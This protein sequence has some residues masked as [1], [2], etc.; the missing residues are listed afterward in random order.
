MKFKALFIGIALLGMVS[1][2]CVTN[3][4]YAELQNKY[5]ELQTTYSSTREDLINCNA[6]TRS[7]QQQ[8][9]SANQNLSLIHISEHTRL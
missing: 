7:L 3:K 4:K 6:D 9:Q 8:L 2:S 1:S 5:D